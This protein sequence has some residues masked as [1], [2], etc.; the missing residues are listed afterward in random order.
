MP[1]VRKQIVGIV[2][3]ILNG[4]ISYAKM[5]DDGS[6]SKL[7][8]TKITDDDWGRVAQL[9]S[10]LI[11]ELIGSFEEIDILPNVNPEANVELDFKGREAKT[12][13]YLLK[14]LEGFLQ[15]HAM[16]STLTTVQ[17]AQLKEATANLVYSCISKYHLHLQVR[18]LLEK[19]GPVAPK[20][21]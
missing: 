21:A 6:R 15:Q 7:I 4:R 3:R 13:Q 14:M 12:I 10:E 1:K 2:F 5:Y 16:I 20:A 11:S 19:Y 17:K 8:R 9:K 18:A